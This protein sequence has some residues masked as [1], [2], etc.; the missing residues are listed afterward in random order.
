MGI[1]Q[2]EDVE[3]GDVITIEPVTCT[4]TRPCDNPPARPPSPG[5]RPQAGHLDDLVRHAAK[6]RTT[7]DAYV[8]LMRRLKSLN[9]MAIAN[10]SDATEVD[11]VAR[12]LAHFYDCGWD[13]RRQALCYVLGEARGGAILR[14]M[15]APA[16]HFDHPD[17]SD[18][19]GHCSGTMEATHQEGQRDGQE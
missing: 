18:K 2:T 10:S 6:S 19:E 12:Q 3:H 11:D 4:L 13:C 15:D 5:A 7:D 14:S 1:R 9:R 8:E 17:G 16:C